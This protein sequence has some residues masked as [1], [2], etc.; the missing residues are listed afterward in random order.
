MSDRCHPQVNKA[1]ASERALFDRPLNGSRAKSLAVG[2]SKNWRVNSGN[3]AVTSSA[4]VLNSSSVPSMIT[5]RIPGILQTSPTERQKSCG[6]RVRRYL[7]TMPSI[8]FTRETQRPSRASLSI[9]FL[10]RRI[11]PSTRTFRSSRTENGSQVVK[12]S[13]IARV[14]TF[15]CERLRHSRTVHFH[16]GLNII[17]S[18]GRNIFPPSLASQPFQDPEVRK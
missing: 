6:S 3:R 10:H 18:V 14:H 11:A 16:N 9:S 13:Q 4:H 15:L 8:L 1:V 5:L 12:F 7:S 2:S 17:L